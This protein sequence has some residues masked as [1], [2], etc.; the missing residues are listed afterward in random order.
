MRPS[1]TLN[2]LPWPPG[3][4]EEPCPHP[5][6]VSMQRALCGPSKG[7]GREGLGRPLF[8]S[9]VGEGGLAISTSGLL[10]IYAVLWVLSLYERNNGPLGPSV[11]QR[12]LSKPRSPLPLRPAPSKPLTPR[13]KPHVPCP[14][15]ACPEKSSRGHPAPLDQILVA[16]PTSLPLCEQGTCHNPSLPPEWLP[17]S[18]PQPTWPCFTWALSLRFSKDQ[19]QQNTKNGTET[20]KQKNHLKKRKKEKKTLKKKKL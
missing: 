20:N 19:N 11:P 16:S 12:H 15:T 7:P 18:Q 14:G 2:R 9:L 10:N 3:G 5:D 17:R 8:L 13:P 6:S 1:A 4:A